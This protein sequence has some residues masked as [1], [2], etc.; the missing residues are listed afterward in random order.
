MTITTAHNVNGHDNSIATWKWRDGELRPI[1]YPPDS[2]PHQRDDPDRQTSENKESP[3]ETIDDLE[4]KMTSTYYAIC[5]DALE[6]RRK[7]MRRR[8]CCLPPWTVQTRLLCAQFPLLLAE[9]YTM[10][11]DMA[12]RVASKVEFYLE[13]TIGPVPWTAPEMRNIC[14]A[15]EQ[16]IADA[17]AG[18]DE[19]VIIRAIEYMELK[20]RQ[21]VQME[22][23]DDLLTGPLRTQLPPYLLM[24]LEE[25]EGLMKIFAK[26]RATEKKAFPFRYEYN[27]H[28]ADDEA[29]DDRKGKRRKTTSEN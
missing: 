15:N 8:N 6:F 13:N 9:Y 20:L 21:D 5:L 12:D 25:N 22:P 29:D 14:N 16:T 17:D 18:N 1:E 4:R 10:H 7:Q 26:L 27:K 19:L 2:P 23:N 11:E 3:R 24:I 28:K